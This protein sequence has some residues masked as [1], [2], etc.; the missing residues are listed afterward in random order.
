MKHLLRK[1]SQKINAN[2]SDS[3]S[4]SDMQKK[5]PGWKVH[6]QYLL[7]L[8]GMIAEEMLS[9]NFTALGPT[10]KDVSQRAYAA[11]D[12]LILFLLDPLAEARRLSVYT[13]HNTRMEATV[14][15]A[16]ERSNKNV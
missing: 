9:E 16:T 5:H 11:A 14:R 13:K 1:I 2:E 4:Y 3:A 12:Q 7:L 10:E 6:Q 15:G 8:R